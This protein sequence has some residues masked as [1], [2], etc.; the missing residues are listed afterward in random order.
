MPVYNE[1]F[2]FDLLG[3]NIMDLQLEVTVKDYDRF[4]KNDVMGKVRL[5]SNVEGESECRHWRE[6]ILNSQKQTK[7]WHSLIK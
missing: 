2:K 5:G 4:S 1:A 6:M 3:K 7:Q